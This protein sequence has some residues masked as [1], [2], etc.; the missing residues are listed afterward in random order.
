MMMI[1]AMI[2]EEMIVVMTDGMIDAM[3]GEDA[4][5]VATM[6]EDVIAAAKSLAETLSPSL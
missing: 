4:P 2:A 1:D 5:I 3:I 6:I